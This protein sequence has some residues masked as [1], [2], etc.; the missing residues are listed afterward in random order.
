M[1]S[2]L[3]AG[4]VAQLASLS[5]SVEDLAEEQAD[6]I[7]SME[8]AADLEDQ[9]EKNPNYIRLPTTSNK[10]QKLSEADMERIVAKASENV[11]VPGTLNEYRQ[12]VQALLFQTLTS[13]NAPTSGSGIHSSNS[14]SSSK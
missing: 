6:E 5:V 12:Y 1:T 11:I 2:N 4:A 7:E 10:K 3:L 14:A 8:S 13:L 9:Q